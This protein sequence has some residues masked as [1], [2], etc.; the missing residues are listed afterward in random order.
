ME[1]K[2]PLTDTRHALMV[3]AGELFAE[4][5]LEGVSIRDIVGKAGATLSAVNYHFGS[6]VKLYQETIR[7]AL[8]RH[9]NAEDT[10]ALIREATL[11]CPQEAADFLYQLVLRFFHTYLAPE[12][13]QWYAR[14]INRAVVDASDDVSATI[15]EVLRPADEAL[16]EM[17]LRHVP[18]LDATEANLWRI[19]LTGQIH[20]FLMARGVISRLLTRGEDEYSSDFIQ[21]AA[22]YVARNM[23]IVLGLP[24]PAHLARHPCPDGSG[25]CLR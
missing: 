5:G 25:D 2:S 21:T 13:P 1:H 6:K 22:A 17:L 4:R 12:H 24:L 18:H 23:V 10:V 20:Y 3:A 11:S 9:I 16:G 19:C 7:Y 15:A 14:L 8:E